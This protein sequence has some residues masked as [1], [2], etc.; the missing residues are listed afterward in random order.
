MRPDI[1]KPCAQ[2]GPEYSVDVAQKTY[3]LFKKFRLHS[4]V[5]RSFLIS[6]TRKTPQRFLEEHRRAL[7]WNKSH[8]A[9]LVDKLRENLHRAEV[10][11]EEFESV[12][13]N[14][15][16]EVRRE[17][18]RLSEVNSCGSPFDD[19]YDC[20]AY[21]IR[22]TDSTFSIPV[23]PELRPSDLSGRTACIIRVEDVWQQK[24]N[25][26]ESV[27]RTIRSLFRGVCSQKHRNLAPQVRPSCD[28]QDRASR[29]KIAERARQVQAFRSYLQKLPRCKE[30][31]NGSP[32]DREACELAFAQHFKAEASLHPPLLDFTYD[33]LVALFFASLCPV[34][35][36]I[37]VVYRLS[38]RSDFER[39]RQL[40]VL[41]ELAIV[42][43]PAITR[44]RSQ[45]AVLL[46]NPTSDVVDQL[47][48]YA[49]KFKQ[50]PRVSFEDPEIGISN[51]A[52]LGGD[53]DLTAFVGLFRN[54]GFEGTQSIE[55]ECD[56]Y[57]AADDLE[58]SLAEYSESR[59]SVFE[60]R[61]DAA[62]ESLRQL[63]RLHVA[64]ERDPEIPA[65]DYS[66]RTLLDATDALLRGRDPWQA[67][68]DAYLQFKPVEMQTNMLTHAALYFP[69]HFGRGRKP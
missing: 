63:A 6:A 33:P 41:G 37:G 67:I 50:L 17:A 13:A 53:A 47:V 11:L 21:M 24:I 51:D 19:V 65:D 27:E 36:E 55:L 15:A 45:R 60:T 25:H 8:S 3:A 56:G 52:L 9:E 30:I 66:I 69:D 1:C 5:S 14:E 64:L 38:P 57:T 44:L 26:N 43:L 16:N 20:A 40:S 34:E 10:E 39:F 68:F 46:H 31:F 32:A 4:D 58:A 49:L 48:P 62:S 18:F 23:Y 12:L 35:G 42:V 54:S 7:K 29:E 22:A 59:A 61:N 2:R 28:G